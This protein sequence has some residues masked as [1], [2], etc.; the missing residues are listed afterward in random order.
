MND[1]TDEKNVQTV[2]AR[3]RRGCLGCLGRG[4]IGLLVFLVVAMAAGAIYQAAA[5]ASDL[6]KYPP[7][8]E[9]YDV[10]DYR[11]H[12]HC[13][14]EGSPTVILEAG[15]GSAALAWYLV[16]KEVAGFTRVCSYDRAGFGWS[17]PASG[18]LLPRQVAEDL[19]KLL[20]AADVPGPYILVGH[21]AGGYYV[22]A[23]A[24][25]YP[26]EVLGLVLVDAVHEQ[27][28]AHYPPEY[29]RL[30][31][32]AYAMLPLCQIMSPF[33]GVR[34]L[35][36]WN[37]AGSSVPAEVREAYLSTLYRNAFCPAM[38]NEGK[39]VS[40]FLSQPDIPGSLGDLYWSE[41][42]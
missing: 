33:G 7:P 41:I 28:D 24:G 15:A 4:A 5:S 8:G 39:A 42:K 17:D 1:H 25:Q 29:V 40:M 3:K 23:Y 20:M 31:N 26:S 27:Q 6:K 16:Q 19:H 35:G 2:S 14:G 30:S 22:R 13:T 21:S 34:T 32:S 38:A 9:L 12:L 11:L 37:A 18:P 36:F 10:G